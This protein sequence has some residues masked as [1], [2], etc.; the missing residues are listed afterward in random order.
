MG[1]SGSISMA[2][3][4]SARFGDFDWLLSVAATVNQPFL[5]WLVEAFL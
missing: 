2:S 3:H 4:N 1:I 5:G